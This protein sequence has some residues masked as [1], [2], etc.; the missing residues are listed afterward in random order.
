MNLKWLPALALATQLQA[1][2]TELPQGTDLS[3]LPQY[4]RREFHFFA[5]ATTIQLDGADPKT[6]VY[7]YLEVA[8]LFDS[9][10]F[11]LD[12]TTNANLWWDF[13]DSGY[14]LRYIFVNEG[15]ESGKI[16]K[17]GITNGPNPID[18]NFN[19]SAFDNTD[20]HTVNLFGRLPGQPV[21]EA[22]MSVT[23]FILALVFLLFYDQKATG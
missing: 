1:G 4:Q 15:E 3:D 20:I 14:R 6:W 11:S 18:G 17:V 2:V 8:G 10:L 16:Y 13:A 9:D 23:L 7:P 21:S 22:D 12:P 19:L 5:E